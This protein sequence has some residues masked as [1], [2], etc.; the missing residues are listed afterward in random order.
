PVVLLHAAG[1]NHLNWPHQIRRLNGYRVLAP[2][3]PGHGKSTGLGAHTIKDYADIILKWLL[4]IGIFQA[5]FIGHSMGGAIAQTIAFD[6]PERIAALGLIATAPKFAISASILEKLGSE[7]GF[8]NA[9]RWI[10]EHSYFSELDKK[11]MLNFSKKLLEIRY[12]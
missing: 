7:K 2:D 11:E 5:I 6:Y 8:Q 1:G 9:A 4:D 12:W 3:L 10:V